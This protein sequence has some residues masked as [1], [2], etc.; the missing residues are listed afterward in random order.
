MRL[1]PGE[2]VPE[3]S[4]ELFPIEAVVNEQNEVDQVLN[5]RI[6]PFFARQRIGVELLREMFLAGN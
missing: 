4:A 3:I 6:W 2:R 1:P 5:P